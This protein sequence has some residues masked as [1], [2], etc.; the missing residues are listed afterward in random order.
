MS[1][2]FILMIKMKQK[3]HIYKEVLVNLLPMISLK[4]KL[5]EHCNDLIL[6]S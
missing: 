4:K 1:H 5:V 2:I 3:E 6:I